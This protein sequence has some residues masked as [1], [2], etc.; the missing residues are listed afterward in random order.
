M[1]I[2][3]YLVWVAQKEGAYK[4]IRES[5]TNDLGDGIWMGRGRKYKT[6]YRYHSLYELDEL[7]ALFGFEAIKKYSLSDDAKLYQK[8]SYSIMNDL[9]SE[10]DFTKYILHDPTIEDPTS[11]VLKTVKNDGKVQ[12]VILNP[13]EISI[14]TLYTKKLDLVHA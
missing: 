13:P 14:E 12:V 10:E 9:L 8:I 6:F 1:K 4:R 7:T 2:G 11:G 5:G 3:K